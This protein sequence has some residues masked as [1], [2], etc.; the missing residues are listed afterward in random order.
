MEEEEGGSACGGGDG[1]CFF[2]SSG[3]ATA[4]ADCDM[5][6]MEKGKPAPRRSFIVAGDDDDKRFC[7][8]VERDGNTNNGLAVLALAAEGTR[9]DKSYSR[10][11]RRRGL[12]REKDR[13]AS[14][15][16]AARDRYRTIDGE[17]LVCG[18][19]WRSITIRPKRSCYGLILLCLRDLISWCWTGD[20]AQAYVAL[21][22]LSNGN[23]GVKRPLKVCV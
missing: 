3:S 12:V 10:R 22:F 13:K 19:W 5:Q 1:G 20:E 21:T 4:T 16:K 14:R 7:V 2:F 15:E 6:P 17:F 23:F 18:I 9:S 8:R 11:R